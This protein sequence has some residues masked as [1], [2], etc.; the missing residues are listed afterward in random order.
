M[1]P[2]QPRDPDFEARIR[3]SFARQRMMRTLGADFEVG[4][5]RGEKVYAA[6][7]TEHPRT[8]RCPGAGFRRSRCFVAGEL[9]LSSQGPSQS[10]RSAAGSRS[11]SQARAPPESGYCSRYRSPFSSSLVG[12]DASFGILAIHDL[13]T[14]GIP[15]SPALLL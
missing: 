9:S 5:V 3:D 15:R 11:I 1:S 12:P 8:G 6:M 13:Q 14:C 7:W 10:L 2:F 4:E